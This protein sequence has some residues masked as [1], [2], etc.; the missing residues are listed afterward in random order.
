M[1]DVFFTAPPSRI[2]P[3]N[4]TLKADTGKVSLKL[5]KTI[6]AGHQSYNLMLALQ[7]GLRYSVGRVSTESSPRELPPMDFG[8]KVKQFFPQ[9]GSDMTPAHTCDEFIWKVR[10]SIKVFG[11]IPQ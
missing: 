9:E 8:L 5:G 6:A 1:V 3:R 11:L 2:I 7:L 4:G 10:V